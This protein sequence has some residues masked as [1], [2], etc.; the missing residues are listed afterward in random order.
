MHIFKRGGI[1]WFELRYEGRHIRRSTRV[2]NARVAGEIASAF[3]TALAKG[4]VGIT[5]RKAAPTFT[6]ALK[7]FLNWSTLEH[8]DH[9]S[10]AWRY[11]T[12][13]VALK[14]FF[15]D[16]P[17]NKITSEEVERFKAVRQAENT[18]VRARD[19]RVPTTNKVRPATVNRELA[20]LKACFNHAM[21]GNYELRNPVT[22]VKMLAEQNE[23][24]RVVSYAEQVSYLAVA[25]P[26]LRDVATLI[27][28]TGMRPDEV[29]TLARSNVNLAQRYL[30]VPN[31]KTKAARRR[32]GLTSAAHEVLRAR[33]G[34]SVDSVYLF[35]CEIDP[36]R[37][38]PKVN[39]AHDR[40]IRDSKVYPF[41]LYDLRHTWA[42][43]ATEAGIDPVT[44]ASMLGH[45]RIQMVMRY[46]HPTQAHQSSAMAKLE[47]HTLAQ[48]EMERNDP[49]P[50]STLVAVIKKRA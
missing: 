47:A 39:N 8:A 37:P 12:S 10:T 28:E 13:S 5:E 36:T 24:D 34:A 48:Q 19:K 16:T 50:P 14:R 43:R 11:K 42:T 46:A 33:L 35:P 30:N 20:C 6:V 49:A 45:S 21:K 2:K 27:L 26:M 32:I 22:R 18:T 29:Y 9:P 25:T 1:Y 41:R 3:H 31:G 15:R 17:L 38:V 7:V 40:A 23:Q 44:L 4:D